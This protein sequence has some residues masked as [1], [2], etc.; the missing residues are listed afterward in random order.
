MSCLLLRRLDHQLER[1]TAVERTP[2]G[3]AD[4]GDVVDR[5]GHV[6]ACGT[7]LVDHLTQSLRGVPQWQGAGW[8]GPDKFQR[9]PGAGDGARLGGGLEGGSNGDRRGGV[10]AACQCCGKRST[11]SLPAGPRPPAHVAGAVPSARL[12]RKWD[13]VTARVGVRPIFGAE[14]ARG[15]NGRRWPVSP[16]VNRSGSSDPAFVPP[17]NP[18][19]VHHGG[20][21][22]P[23]R[24]STQHRWL[25]C[26]V[27]D[28]GTLFGRVK[29]ASCVAPRAVRARSSTSWAVSKRSGS[30]ARRLPWTHF[31]SIGLSQGLLTGNRQPTMRTPCP[32][33]LTARLWSRTQAYTSRLTCQ[34]ALSQ[35]SSRAVFPRAASRSQHQARNCVVRALTGRPSTKRSSTSLP[36]GR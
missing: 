32:A 25:W 31:G 26:L 6:L 29:C 30:T 34:E 3:L 8:A 15:R 1:D 24:C 19:E 18:P 21:I 33:R 12:R 22:C 7:R 23:S 2:Q 13:H 4:L 14:V 17:F 5:I 16:T 36:A 11:A 35:T 9:L 28:Q 27:H 10:G 20:R